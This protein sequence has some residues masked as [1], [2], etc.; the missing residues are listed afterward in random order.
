MASVVHRLWVPIANARDAFRRRWLAEHGAFYEHIWRLV[1]IH[2]SVAVMLGSA[3][4][5]NLLHNLDDEKDFTEKND[6][7]AMLTG[8]RAGSGGEILSGGSDNA[9]LGGSIGTWL[10]LLNRFGRRDV[11]PASQFR[12]HLRAYLDESSGQQL[13]FLEEWRRV[14]P[15]P[16]AYQ[17][18]E[19]TRI[20][21]VQAINSLRNKL[22]HVPISER[23]LKNLYK[24]LRIEIFSLLTP[25]KIDPSL[26][27][28]PLETKNWFPVL[29]GS[30][31]C[32]DS[33]LS[34]TGDPAKFS[35]QTGSTKDSADLL[36]RAKPDDKSQSDEVWSAAPFLRADGELKVGVL[37]RLPGIKDA[38][39]ESLTGEYHRFAAEIEPVREEEVA[40]RLISILLPRIPDESKPDPVATAPALSK[41]TSAHS[42]TPSRTA[43]QIRSDAEA[44]FARRD[45]AA[46]A[47]FFR[48]LSDLNDSVAYNHVAMLKHGV[49]LRRMAQERPQ[50]QDRLKLIHDATVL[51]DDATNH[52]DV[53]YEARARYE[54]SR[55]LLQRFRYE[56]ES[57]EKL[58]ER[59]ISEAKEAAKLVYEPEYMNWYER[60]SRT[61]DASS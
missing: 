27:S 12:T 21:R 22:A 4:A 57:D 11:S 58:R 36:W 17:N 40:A 47:E 55:A 26:Q 19:L 1:H 3:L 51:L 15:V 34:G 18:N 48:E 46:S 7:R 45:Y 37:F 16:E 38:S 43:Y 5:T 29:R 24:G 2:E 28:D 54:L 53:T 20:G 41:S 23:S 49:S 60:I 52:L 35:K 6:L 44:A 31:V 8:I 25:D 14:G 50:S 61:D 59:A 30:I 13:A 9:C 39:D 56:H 32:S 42:D 33:V 10:D